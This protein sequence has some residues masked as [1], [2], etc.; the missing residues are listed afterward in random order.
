MPGR[1]R[2]RPR[3]VQPE[4]RDLVKRKE[5]CYIRRM[6]LKRRN[7][8]ADRAAEEV[9]RPLPVR[10]ALMLGLFVL[11]GALWW[12]HFDDRLR[13]IEARTTFWD[14]TGAWTDDDRR[15]LARRARLFREQWGMRLLAHVRTGPLEL[16]E[17]SGTTLFI[18]IAPERGEAVLIVPGL[19][20][21]A[22]KAESA[23]QG[24]DVRLELERNLALCVR[25][26]PA[27]DCLM[28]TLDSLNTLFRAV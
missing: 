18:G 8:E 3:G 20:A 28:Q 5:G 21:G 6:L 23:R 27:K 7:R 17:L 12:R 15:D 13:L 24:R 10:W 9:M 2:A 1:L 19:A 26:R 16:P 14:E 22:L 11:I 4:G 25:D